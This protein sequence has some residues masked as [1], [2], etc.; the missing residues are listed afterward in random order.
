MVSTIIS[1][2]HNMKLRVSCCRMETEQLRSVLAAELTKRLTNVETSSFS[3]AEV[4]HGRIARSFLGQVDTALYQAKQSGRNKVV[5]DGYV[6][7]GVPQETRL[8]H[9]PE[10]WTDEGWGHAS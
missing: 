9:E 4:L 5:A 3:A 1:L 2:A 7:L 10:S 6:Y 8:I